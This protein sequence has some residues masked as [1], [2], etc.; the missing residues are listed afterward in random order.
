MIKSLL[1]TCFFSLMF[2]VAMAQGR[3][4]TGTVTG[5][6]TE[7]LPG[8]NVIVT[9]TSRGTVTDLNGAYSI[10]L[11]EGEN[12]IA[13]SFIG[14]KAQTAEVGDRSVVDVVLQSDTETLQ[15]V[16][17]VG[18][19][20]QKKT[21]ITG[22]TANVKGEEL[23]RQPVLTATQ[24]LQGKVSGVQIISSGQPGSSP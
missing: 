8:V 18:Y 2:L 5:D 6:D 17:V 10:E 7:P 23:F 1:T 11:R 14:Y 12:S 19:G 24:A 16:V 22:A 13:F 21:D 3:T 20:V 9:G 4:V 15:E